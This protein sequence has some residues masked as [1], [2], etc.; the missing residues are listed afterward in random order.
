M[1]MMD[2]I[3]EQPDVFARA[4]ANRASLAAPFVEL[5]R[6][7]EPD[8]LYIVAS[9]TSRNASATAAPFMSQV[10]GMDVTVS[11]PSR[12]YAVYGQRPL[13]IY[14]SQ[15]GNSTNTIAAMERFAAIPSLA[16]TG[17]RGRICDLC[18][19]YTAIPCGPETVGPKTKGYTMTILGLYLLALET[20]RATGR[21]SEADYETYMSTLTAAGQAMAANVESTVAWQKV[22][23]E[24]QRGLKAAYLVGKGQA[25]RIA[26]E[27]ALKLQETLLIPTAAF[28]FEEFLH[29]PTSSIKPDVA[30]FY[31]V[32]PE[33]DPDRRRMLDLMAYHRS[34][35]P[36]VYTL[37]G[38]DAA[39]PRD[40]TLQVTGRWY[41][42]PFE[43][44]LP[45]QVVSAAVP[46]ELGIENVSFATF[47]KLDMLLNI[48]FKGADGETEYVQPGTH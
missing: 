40:C 8:R 19:H 46:A 11:A 18:Q 27:G 29:G 30:G 7:V 45:M 35:C 21:L 23:D 16:M 26:Q 17:D 24:A 37:G 14:V 47:H 6:A 28:D 32:P 34:V 4:L 22:N 42:Q 10:L 20:A 44:I 39:D 13:M 41:T 2:Y 5:F 31:L 33:G 38:P 1:N 25:L 36:H 3:R 9:G 43:Y 12:L 48:K 15:G